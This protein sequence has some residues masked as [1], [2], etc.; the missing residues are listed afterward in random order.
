MKVFGYVCI[1]VVGLYLGWDVHCRLCLMILIAFL[2][3]WYVIICF[4]IF[5]VV[6]LVGSNL[7]GKSCH[8]WTCL[9]YYFC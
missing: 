9:Y 7:V 1:L 5:V 4:F 3:R 6:F 8:W 2:I